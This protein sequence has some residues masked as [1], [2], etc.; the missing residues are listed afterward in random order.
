MGEVELRLRVLSWNVGMGS[1]LPQGDRH[2]AAWA[3]VTARTPLPDVLLLQQVVPGR[4]ADG[5]PVAWGATVDELGSRAAVAARPGLVVTPLD[6]GVP[7]GTRRGS[8]SGTAAAVVAVPGGPAWTF[9]SVSVAY[10]DS[11]TRWVRHLV[12]ELANAAGPVVLGGDLN[13]PVA[14][15]P[16]HS[17]L[18]GAAA[19]AGFDFVCGTGVDVLA[20]TE[21]SQTD[22][23]WVRGAGGSPADWS[24]DSSVRLGPA[25][26]ATHSALWLSLAV[27]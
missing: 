1:P 13:R 21:T 22:H 17:R 20:T 18:F 26:L 8:A 25:P 3:W 4:F 9:V 23:L 12:R 15:P 2:A 11:G 27:R 14:R 19:A 10:D 5:W 16:R 7:V 24:I 6:L